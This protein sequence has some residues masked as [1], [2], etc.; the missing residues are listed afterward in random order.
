[1]YPKANIKQVLLAHKIARKSTLLEP[2]EI[3]VKA[4]MLDL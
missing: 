2:W 3:E 4:Y 1:M